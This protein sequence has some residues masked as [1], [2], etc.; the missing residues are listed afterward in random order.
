MKAIER[1]EKINT[2]LD[3]AGWHYNAMIDNLETLDEALEL[4]EILKSEIG[5]AQDQLEHIL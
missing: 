5:A 1:L 3:N 2:V 4:I